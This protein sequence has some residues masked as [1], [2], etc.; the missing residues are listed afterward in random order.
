[1]IGSPAVKKAVVH[2]SNGKKFTMLA[3]NVSDQNIYVQSVKLNGKN[4][5]RPF[6]PYRELKNGGALIFTMG[7]QP[8]KEWG[9]NGTVPE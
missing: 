4:W 3:E 7:P 8:N 2:L 9:T 5:D 1:V 6:L